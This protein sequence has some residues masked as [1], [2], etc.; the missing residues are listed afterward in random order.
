MIKKTKILKCVPDLNIEILLDEGYTDISKL[1]WW[2]LK[3]DSAYQ[4]AI[5]IIKAIPSDYTF[6]RIGDRYTSEFKLKDLYE[7]LE[8]VTACHRNETYFKKQ[9]EI[10][11][12]VNTSV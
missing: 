8:E 1:D 6:P 2:L 5:S 4:D 11:D 7:F 12:E 9:L 3:Y 10:H